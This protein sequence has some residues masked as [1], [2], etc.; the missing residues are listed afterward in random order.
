MGSTRPP[1]GPSD[2]PSHVATCWSTTGE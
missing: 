1:S 2:S